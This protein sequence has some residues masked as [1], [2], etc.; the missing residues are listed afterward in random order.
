[1]AIT[2]TVAITN[3]ATATTLGNP[4]TDQ[5]TI[6]VKLLLTLSANYGGAATHGDTLSFASV[7]N[8]L[9][10]SDA[11]PVNVSVYEEPPAGTAPNGYGLCYCPGTTRDNGVVYMSATPGGAEYTEGTA[12]DA[13]HLAAYL[14]AIATF[15]AFV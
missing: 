7:N 2:P 6:V 13:G 14:Y 4:T 10:P 3:A 15:P 1:M 12:Y 11:V 9:I 8:P 5:K